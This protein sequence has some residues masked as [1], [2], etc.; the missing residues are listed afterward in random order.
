MTTDFSY[1]L[2]Q[3]P[4]AFF[5]V[6]AALAGQPLRPHHRSDFDFDEGALDVTAAIWVRLVHD[7]LGGGEGDL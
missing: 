6:G 2:Q 5:F 7:L 1:F 4:G 3:R